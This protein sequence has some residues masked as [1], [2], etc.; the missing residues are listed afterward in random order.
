MQSSSADAQSGTGMTHSSIA[1]KE[2]RHCDM[3]TVAAVPA[4]C[5]A[6]CGPRR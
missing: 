6:R 4:S 1:V 5:W 2:D 3:L